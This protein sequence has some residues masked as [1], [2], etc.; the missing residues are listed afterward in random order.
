[1]KFLLTLAALLLS[2]PA[3]TEARGPRAQKSVHCEAQKPADA[4]FTF[5]ADWEPGASL[6]NIRFL[7][8]V[9]HKAPEAML[10][11]RPERNP[12]FRG[13]SRFLL[14]A[15]GDTLAI[16]LPEAYPARAE[17]GGMFHQYRPGVHGGSLVTIEL[18]CYW[19]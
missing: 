15:S 12:E 4:P 14:Q 10:D 19:N 11:T 8:R 1:M 18:F 17:F 13:F 7:G 2:V 3:L 5:D 16:R 9:E 6:R